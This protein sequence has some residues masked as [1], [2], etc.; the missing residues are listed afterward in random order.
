VRV[1]GWLL[2][3]EVGLSDHV[4]CS[5]SSMGWDAI[6]EAG[7]GWFG[8]SADRGDG[9]REMGQDEMREVIDGD[10]GDVWIGCD[11]RR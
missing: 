5:G 6:L 9:W 10:Y 1:C 11:Y 7:V 4:E 2:S 8:G 3:A